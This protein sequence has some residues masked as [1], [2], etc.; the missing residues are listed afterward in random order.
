MAEDTGGLSAAQWAL[1]FPTASLDI[2]YICIY[3]EIIT[4]AM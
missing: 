3:I 1:F 2:Q 4:D